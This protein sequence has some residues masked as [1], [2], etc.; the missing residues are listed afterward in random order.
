MGNYYTLADAR[1]DGITVAEASNDSV[2]EKIN[3]AEQLLE[4]WTGRIFYARDLSLSLDGTG[5]EYLDLRRYR[6]INSI[7]S[8][9]IDDED[10]DVDT[11]IAIYEDEGFLRIKR[12]GWSV[13]QGN[14]LGYYAFT[15]GSQNI[16]VSGNFGYETVP[17]PIKKVIRLM[18]IREIRPRD[19]VGKFESK[20]IGNFGYKLNIARGAK[21][22]KGEILT[23]DPEID[24]IIHTYKHKIS[25]KAVTRGWH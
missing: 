24:R 6:P 13:Y 16:D 17:A 5:S 25:F 8:L 12:E 4:K 2:N 14:R 9:S 10:I 19:K 20:H 21:G 7:S 11:Y 22:Q 18:T 3:E 23:G 15:R 1:A